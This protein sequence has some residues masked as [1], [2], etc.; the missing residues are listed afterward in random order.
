MLTNNPS[1]TYAC[2]LNSRRPVTTSDDRCRGR[3]RCVQ[4]AVLCYLC[5]PLRM[6]GRATGGSSLILPGSSMLR[7][8]SSV[9][10]LR[11]QGLTMKPADLPKRFVCLL[12][13]CH[14]REICAYRGLKRC[15]KWLWT[16]AVNPSKANK[17]ESSPARD[18]FWA[19]SLVP[20][21]FSNV[22]TTRDT[23]LLLLVL[24]VIQLHSCTRLWVIGFGQWQKEG[25]H[26]YKWQKSSSTR[27]CEL[28][29]KDR[30]RGLVGFGH[31]TRMPMN[32]GMDKE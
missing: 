26:E 29:L 8:P 11:K 18:W 25:E 30:L 17:P 22:F 16:S 10:A 14:Q 12:L 28:R 27:E 2:T 4:C 20:W 15:L 32:T 24:A 13:T 7:A 3:P 23:P 5:A 6:P 31:L 21:G 1:N 9:R 19:N